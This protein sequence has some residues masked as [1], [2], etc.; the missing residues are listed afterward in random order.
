MDVN[1][2][3][4]LFEASYFAT[5]IYNALQFILVFLAESV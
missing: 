5:N 1:S 2:D 4:G 3:R